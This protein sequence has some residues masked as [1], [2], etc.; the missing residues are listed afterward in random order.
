LPIDDCPIIIPLNKQSFCG[1]YTLPKKKNPNNFAVLK[2][3]IA[4]LRS[5]EGCPW[6]RKQTH[7]SLRPYLIE[8][9]YEVLQALEKGT[10]QKL[11]EE[12]GDLLLQIML[13][14]QIAAEAEQ[15]DI[16][17]VVRGISGKLVHRHPHVFGGRK[18]QDAGEVELNW[19]ALKQEEREEGE[20]L[21]S[22]VP[23]QMPALAYSQSIQRRVAGVGFDWEEVDEII[24]KLAEE[25]AEI[26][27]APNQQEKAQEFGDLLFTLANIARR[28]DIDLEMTLR[29]AN[30][31]FCRRFACMEKLCRERG[32]NFSSLSLDEQ[33]ALWEEAKRKLK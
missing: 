33:N 24:D 29:S 10:P 26:K 5:P 17:D 27:Q 13:H 6:D 7:A 20:S 1:I 15:F 4:K 12:L 2:E 14:A 16:D 25:V 31:R 3:I 19:Q 28:L 8:E 22:G 30:Q 9:C 18:V 32:L 21:L 11:C 23:E